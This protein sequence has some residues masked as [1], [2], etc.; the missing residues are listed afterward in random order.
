MHFGQKASLDLLSHFKDTESLKSI[1]SS[2]R[3][4][5]SWSDKIST[6]GKTE[7][8]SLILEF[9]KKVLHEDK[10]EYLNKIMWDSQALKD[11]RE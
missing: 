6:F 2:L 1:C 9:I 5:F 7:Q 10:C 4:I 8:P 3:S 11:V